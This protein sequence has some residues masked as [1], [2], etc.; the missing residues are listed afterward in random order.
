MDDILFRHT[1]IATPNDKNEEFLKRAANSECAQKLVS[2]A[3]EFDQLL[4]DSLDVKVPND[5]AGKI[6]LEQSFAIEHDKTM[7]NRW[8]IAIAASIAFI[9]GL[10]LPMLKSG[11]APNESFDATENAIVSTP[12]PHA[13]IGSVA[14]QHVQ[15]EYFLTAKVNEQASI[16]NV[17]V[18]LARYGGTAKPGLGNIYFVNYCS[19]EGS[20]ALHMI[21]EGEKG[22]VTVF[23]VPDDAGFEPSAEFS[24]QHFKGISEHV[25]KANV[26]IVGEQDE[27]LNKMKEKLAKTIKWDI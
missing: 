2:E 11:I 9:I 19:F 7:S 3:K 8:H 4:K 15:K 14:L 10:S 16:Q 20:S 27:P 5:L 6:L 12:A 21:L 23:V 1:A 18:K 26:V 13:D 24:N 22:R 17:N 25:G